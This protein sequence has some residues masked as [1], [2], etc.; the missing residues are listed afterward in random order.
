M[1]PRTLWL[2]L[3]LCLLISGC[4]HAPAEHAL[5]GWTQAQVTAEMGTPRE[6][7]DGHYGAP[8]HSFTN[9]FPGPVRTLVFDQAGGALYVSLEQR[10]G[11]WYVIS[12]SWLPRGGVF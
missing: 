1:N 2:P 9:R 5:L 7:C 6:Q 11:T 3:L 10:S 8:P 4:H 12:N